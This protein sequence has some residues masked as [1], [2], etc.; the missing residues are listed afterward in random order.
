MKDPMTNQE[1]PKPKYLKDYQK[2]LF[3]IENVHLT[4][5]LDDTNTRVT[6]HMKLYREPEHSTEPL[7]LNGERMKLISIRLNEKD[8]NESD[9]IVDE[10]TLTI[11]EVPQRCELTIVN[12]INP[13]ANTFL[14]GLYKSKDIFCTQNEPQGFRKI[15][16]FLDRPDVMTSYTTKIIADK[17]K[18]PTLLSNGNKINSGDLPDN[19]HFV[20]WEDPFKKPSYLFALVAGNLEC[21]E[22]SF[23]RRS[24]KP[25]Q[26]Q[27]FCEKKYKDKCHHAMESLK[28]SMKW[29]EDVFD[30]EYDLDIFMIV[31]VDAFN[32]GAMEN[33]GL[34]IFNTSCILADQE[35][36]TDDNFVRVEKVIAHEYFHNWTGDR[37]TL[38][39]WFQLTLKEGL[40]VFRDQEFTS[41]MSSRP[42]HRIETVNILRGYQFPEDAGPTAHPIRPS[43]YIEMNNFYTTT[44]YDKGSEVIRMIYTLL[45]KEAFFEGMKK[46]FE[47]YDGNAITCDDFIHAMEISSKR[48]FTQ[49]KRWYEQKGTPHLK[50]QTEYDSSS[51]T[52]KLH[53]EQSN[54]HEGKE[55]PPLH[56]P[57]KLGLLN[58]DGKDFE[59]PNLIEVKE[60][61]E[62]FTFD[63]ISEK[64]I[65]S[66]NREFS[67]PVIIDTPH[68]PEEYSFLMAYDSDDFNRWEASQELGTSLLLDLLEDYR[69]KKELKLN[70][71]YSEAFRLLLSNPK[72]DLG[73][74][75]LALILPTENTLG[76]K[77]KT[78]DFDG[79]HYVRNWLRKELGIAHKDLFLELYHSLEDKDT[80]SISSEAMS[81]RR[82]K[83]CCLAY[84]VHIQEKE[85]IELAYNQF[86]QANN[87]TD[88]FSALTLLNQINCP[89]REEAL[90]RF[91][92]KWNKDLLVMV[93]W[94]SIQ[95]LCPLPG[96]LNQVEK[97][98]K[99][100]A[101]DY[102]IPN[103][104]RALIGS[105]LENHIHF[106]ALDGSGYRF[107]QEQISTLDKINPQITARL[108]TAFRKFPKLDIKRHE[109]MKETLETLINKKDLS[110][111][112]YEIVSK[113]LN[114]QP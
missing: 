48:D 25:V 82:L 28:K 10:K 27:I 113:S 70:T 97:L 22:D 69:H 35:S 40:T 79:N 45:G 105:F 2:P 4:F 60:K 23:M 46:Y 53:V 11:K 6:T 101:F 75:T 17:N 34:N 108:S 94:L 55:T 89:Q 63:N 19:K 1:P 80:Y 98:V 26:L 74:K 3:G 67:A 38:R 114:A 102:K 18:Y 7:L 65:L 93:K 71:N 31:A 47:L 39:D 72:L 21:L 111:N 88:E 12:E 9:Y 49:F 62:T 77:Q 99:H 106:H 20:E 109:L 104:A 92:Q 15:A 96:A 61:Q 68:T 30:L 58:S 29:D 57:L 90:D 76:Q 41:D 78:I 8:L 83:N 54:P 14:D 13:Q 103:L 5:D 16:Y 42:V 84:L 66:I 87:M 44:V 107:F 91:Y 59:T 85:Y 95:A 36:A 86:T 50:I 73:L 64:P 81:K 24:G 37:V 33:K 100:S 51:Q 43:S 32:A 112:T 52:F 110:R 56:F